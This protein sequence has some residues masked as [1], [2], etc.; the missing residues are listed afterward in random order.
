M[1]LVAVRASSAQP[2][3][4]G[5]DLS[6]EE[7]ATLDLRGS[8]LQGT[9]FSHSGLNGAKFANATLCDTKFYGV[10]MTS[11]DLRG[12][13]FSGKKVLTWSDLSESDLRGA[14]LSEANLD[15]CKLEKTKLN[16]AD[17]RRA[18]LHQAQ[19]VESDL[20]KA[21]LAGADLLGAV[22]VGTI[23]KG[24][25]LTG[26]RIYGIAA[27]DLQSEGAKQENLLI[28]PA[29]Q[30]AITVDNLEVAQFMYVMLYNPKVREV[31][32]T[33][34]SKVVLILGSFTEERKVVLDCIRSELRNLNLIPVLFDFDRP[35]SKDFTGTVE[36]L[37]RMARF[38]LADLTDPSSI[39][40]ELATITPLLRT[41]PVLPLRLAG[42]AGYSM[43][44]D[45]QGA[46]AWVLPSHEYQN[47]TSLIADLSEVIAPAVELANKLQNRNE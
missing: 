21:E 31:L 47:G 19:L 17:L 44:D 12:A 28:T 35:A 37:A 34:T 4:S 30:S 46:Y 39:P 8:I 33:I 1:E 42:A 45:Y 27:W 7:F 26:A 43:F 25:D 29:G 20:T 23:L 38:I 14:D 41:T 6:E 16:N 36:T 10:D 22:L 3:L 24:A 11:A 13:I 9:D 15:H 5:E 40:H 18:Q 32:D 2:D